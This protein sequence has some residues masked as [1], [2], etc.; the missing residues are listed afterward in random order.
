MG[1]L[2]AG[3]DDEQLKEVYK[4]IDRIPVIEVKY[5]VAPVDDRNEVLEN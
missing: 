3:F 1:E 2:K 4:S 5:T